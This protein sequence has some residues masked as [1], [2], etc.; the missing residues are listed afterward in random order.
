MF[1]V[2]A[3]SD[4]LG[5]GFFRQRLDLWFL[6]RVVRSRDSNENGCLLENVFFTRFA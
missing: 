5:S 1:R 2:F 4:D 6:L 3:V